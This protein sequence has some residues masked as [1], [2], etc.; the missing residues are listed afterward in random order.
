MGVA[1]R[2]ATIQFGPFDLDLQSGELSRLGRKVRLQGQS[3]QILAVLLARP[4]E[5]VTREE[6]H[7]QLWPAD[8]FV[9]FDHGLNNAIKRLREALSD[10][11]DKPRYIETLPRKGYRFVGAIKS[12]EA[13]PAP[14]ASSPPGPTAPPVPPA[15]ALPQGR[16]SR[17]RRLRIPVLISAT[18]ILVAGILAAL[19]LPAHFQS[20]PPIHSIAVLPLDNFSGDA[21]QTYFADGITDAITTQLA[22]VGSLRVMSRTS[23]SKYR[24]GTTSAPQIARELKVDAVVEGSIERQGD[25]VRVKAQLVLASSD[26]QLWAKTYDRKMGD[27]L[28][29]E[30]EVAKD[31][32]TH[33]KAALTPGEESRLSRERTVDPAAY[34]LYLQGKYYS[35]HLNKPDNDRAIALF[36]QAIADDPEFAPIYAAIS[37][38][39]RTRGTELDRNNDDAR[40]KAFV[41]TQKCLELDPGMAD[42]YTARSTLIWNYANHFPTAAA[43]ADLK[44]AL[45]LNP[46]S[47]EAHQQ[48]GNIYNHIGLLE[49]AREQFQKAEALNPANPGTRFRIGVNLLYAGRYED[50]L[51]S[52]RDSRRFLPS[53]WAYQ[54]SFAMYQLGRRAEAAAFLGGAPQDDHTDTAALLRGMEA[55][56]AASN[57]DRRLAHE[58]IAQA[59]RLGSGYQHFH[60][61]EYAVASAYAL[62]NQHEE[63]LNW[64]KRAAEDGF[65]CYPLYARDKDL[66]NLRSDPRFIA[67]LGALHDQWQHNNATL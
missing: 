10:S 2:S 11:A 58:K 51:Q 25:D 46:N 42:C 41:A 29:L 54:T 21:A 56:L 64:L 44:H 39:Y 30:S 26:R 47:D 34:D 9:D 20:A 15:S 62:M 43:V 12:V 13:Q 48:L 31:I 49:K 17:S 22:Q 27:I 7:Q 40:Q 19:F 8:T 18:L 59:V 50:A 52:I 53:L 67:F 6:L 36:E 33:V 35:Q 23:A 37:Y 57:G 16:P 63:A 45:A 3:F 55:I 32:V 65:P 5:V 28:T 1:L 38:E 66:D 60:H 4:G 24:H 61:T 14:L